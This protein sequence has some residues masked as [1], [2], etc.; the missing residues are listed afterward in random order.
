MTLVQKY[1]LSAYD[2]SRQTLAKA[3]KA[4]LVSADEKLVRKVADKKLAIVKF[5]KLHTSEN[6][7]CLPSDPSVLIKIIDIAA[8]L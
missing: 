3:A 8:Q 1:Q 7:A 6:P 5:R 4:I 2:S